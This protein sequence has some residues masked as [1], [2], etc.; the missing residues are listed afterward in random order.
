MLLGLAVP[1]CLLWLGVTLLE[2][3]A[4]VHDPRLP[5]WQPFAIFG[6]SGVAAIGLLLL[7][8]RWG[9]ARP[10]DRLA[11]WFRSQLLLMPALIAVALGLTYGLRLAVFSLAGTSY[12]YGKAD[13]FIFYQLI[14]VAI[15]YLLWLGL[16]LAARLV[17]EAREQRRALSLIQDALSAARTRPLDRR[18]LVPLGDKLKPVEIESICWIEADDNYVRLH[19]AT[20][21]Y[22]V[23]KP[24]QDMLAELGEDKFVRIHRSAAINIDEI[25]A[26]KPLPKGDAEIRLKSGAILRMSR[27]FRQSVLKSRSPSQ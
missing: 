21:D 4:I 19:T 2:D 10:A 22:A 20:H 11:L 25:D 18:I 23:R 8:H 15:F 27:R 17:V 14:K 13:G 12:K 6:S 9:A 3:P 16:A 1:W 7:W 24:L 26:I 5:F